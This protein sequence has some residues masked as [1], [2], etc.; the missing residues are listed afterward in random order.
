MRTNRIDTLAVEISMSPKSVHEDI[1]LCTPTGSDKQPEASATV[2]FSN[3]LLEFPRFK[4]YKN[5]R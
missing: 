5:K 1:V 4:E 3:V 2:M